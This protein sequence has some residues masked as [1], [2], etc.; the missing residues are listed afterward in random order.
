MVSTKSM[1]HELETALA[2]SEKEHAISEKR[3][4]EIHSKKLLEANLCNGDLKADIGRLNVRTLVSCVCH[5][6]IPY[7]H[8][9]NTLQ[10]QIKTQRDREKKQEQIIEQLREEAS[11]RANSSILHNELVDLEECFVA[12]EDLT[13]NM[14]N[15]LI[16]F[17]K[18][19]HHAYPKLFPSK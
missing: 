11:S 12:G 13:C 17:K 18:Q 7:A 14:G 4:I 2:Q 16:G 5:D 1:Q 8:I 19:T 3:L 9:C 10:V 15:K 6:V